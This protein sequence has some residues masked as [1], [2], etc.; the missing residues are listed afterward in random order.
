MSCLLAI[1]NN[2]EQYTSSEKK[3]AEYIIENPSEIYKLSTSELAELTKTST[4]SVVRFAKKLGYEGFQELKIELARENAINSDIKEDYGYIDTHDSVKDIILKIG[5]KNMNII[6]ETVKLL[7]EKQVGE[8]IKAILNARKVYLFG[9]GV[10]GLIA[11]DLQ[12]KLLRINKNVQ[13]HMDSHMQMSLAAL[14]TSE[15]LAIAISYSG[16]TREVYN[17][18]S[19]AKKNGAKCISITKYGSNPISEI[20]DIRLQVSG[21]E[22]DIRVGAISSRIAQLTLIDILFVGVAKENFDVV[23][24]YL[25][26]TRRMVSDLKIKK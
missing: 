25:K 17:C 10:S 4:A 11:M 7:D 9:V 26:A 22:K 19:E 23:E 14:T 15:D 6:E 16:R 21:I 5:R 13:T 3:I 12:H 8:A 18:L 24:K 1:K 20:S 2:F